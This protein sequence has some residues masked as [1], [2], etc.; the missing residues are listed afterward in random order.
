MVNEWDVKFTTPESIGEISYAFD[1]DIIYAPSAILFKSSAQQNLPNECEYPQDGGP[2]GV[3][4]YSTTEFENAGYDDS[5]KSTAKQ[6]GDF[7]YIRTY[8][9]IESGCDLGSEVVDDL[10]NLDNGFKELFKSIDAI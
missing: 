7:V 3:F 4:R 5:A 6:V 9:Y 1:N 10:R 8:P 2:W